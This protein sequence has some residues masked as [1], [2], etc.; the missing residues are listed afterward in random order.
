MSR[1]INPVLGELSGKAGNIVGRHFGNEHYVSVRPKKYEVKKKLKQ[2]GSKQR[3]YHVVKLAKMITRRCPELKEAW[4]KCKMPG[5]R[6]YNRI[7]STNYKY[8]KDNLPSTENIIS[9]KGPELL[10]DMLEVN[11]KG[12][13]LSYDMRGL[14]KPSFC[15]TLMIVFFNPRNK[16][17]ALNEISINKIYVE[18][19]YADQSLDEKGEKYIHNY[20]F[21]DVTN[22]YRQNY[23]N[24]I[25]Y[26][27]AVETTAIKKRKWWTS[28]IAIDISRF[29]LR[30]QVLPSNKTA[31]TKKGRQKN[32]L[33]QNTYSKKLKKAGV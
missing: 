12:I 29:K 18:E 9:P 15:L 28:T 10:I 30:L 7:I 17:D 20:Y 4:N 31:G 16:R 6:G 1:L 23:K 5:K 25:L 27:A 22:T 26:A 21:D 19:E 13:S 32:S 14:I 2:V 33:L 8:L 24:A 11:A 3:F